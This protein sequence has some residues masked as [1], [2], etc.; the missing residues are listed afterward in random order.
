MTPP[1]R[2]L[3]TSSG[4]VL[5]AGAALPLAFYPYNLW[6]IALLSPA[7]LVYFCVNSSPRP[8]FIYGY[9][10]GLAMFG[11]GTG[12]IHISINLF[13]GVN[14]VGAVLLTFFFVMFIALFPALACYLS[15]RLYNRHYPKFTMLLVV[16]AAWTLVEWVRS[17]IFTGFPWLNLGYS[18]TDSALAGIAPVAGTF[19][20]SFAVIF[21]AAALLLLWRENMVNRLLVAIMLI[22]IWGAGWVS[23]RHDWTVSRPDTISVALVQ[24]AVPQQLKWTPEMRQPTLDRYME[25]TRPHL[26]SDLIIWPEAAIP[27]FYDQIEPYINNLLTL[28]N[29]RNSRL[30]TGLPYRDPATNKFYNS[31]VML[32]KDVSFYFK[33]HLVPFGEY[34][35][36]DFVLRP[37][38]DFLNIPMSDFS[39][40]DND[41]APVIHTDSYGIG[42]SICYE[43]TFGEEVIQALP[44]AAILVNVS[45]DAWFGDSA[46]P[47]Q[48]LQMARMRAIET[49][50]YLLRATNTGLTAIINE[51]GKVMAHV[52]QFTPVTLSGTAILFDGMTPYARAGNYLVLLLISVV[53]VV[54]AG[55]SRYGRQSHKS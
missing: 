22:V 18:Q 48:H 1:S 42:V 49:G 38:V 23:S 24:G 32:D 9:L 10:Y 13:G 44:D 19:A 31:V 25:L 30:I 55:L 50:R 33:R 37:I 41:T 29:A 43:D 40:G 54:T 3:L 15:A 7:L 12:W 2:S 16:P 21:T 36:L 6:L 39:A 53:L 47:H 46:A 52:P 11:V 27:A 4:L 35:P 14:L 17:W 51:K 28:A 5:L 20:I 45:N 34:L 26:G 8:A